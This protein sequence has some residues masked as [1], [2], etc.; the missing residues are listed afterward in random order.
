MSTIFR[1][2]NPRRPVDWR[3]QLADVIIARGGRVRRSKSDPQ[4]QKAISFRRQLDRCQDDDDYMRVLDSAPEL[5]EA[6][7]LFDDGEDRETR[8]ELE[9][10]LL[11]Q[12][13]VADIAKA[14]AL[15]P[16]SVEH[17]EALFFNVRDRL[18][19][20]SYISQVVLGK[21]IH[22]G[23]SERAYDVLWKMYGYWAGHHVLN[24]LVYRFNAPAIPEGADG[25]NAFWDD[26]A[27]DMLRMKSAIAM[28]TMPINWETQ[29]E[30]LNLYLRMI[31]IERNAGEGGAGSEAVLANIN[32]LFTQIPWT[33]HRPGIDVV[34]QNDPIAVV[35][36]TGKT[37]RAHELS[38]IA[39]DNQMP[40]ALEYLLETMQF[41]ES[42]DAEDSKKT[43]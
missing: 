14:I 42:N 19:S 35:D 4:L 21:S 36:A 13:P 25:V 22:S 7:A 28:R 16:A 26:D 1:K 33:K 39:T 43:Q 27:K 40:K 10:R 5:Y 17:Y 3:W 30:I 6:W 37:L 2:N 15:E 9:A 31:E 20:P 32:T 38:L 34:D 29:T 11:S 12:Q 24:S 41:P 23:L 8:W 18:E